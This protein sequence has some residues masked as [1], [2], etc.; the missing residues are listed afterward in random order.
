LAVIAPDPVHPELPLAKAI[1]AAEAALDQWYRH[2]K[3]AA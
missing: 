2:E 3:I 1:R